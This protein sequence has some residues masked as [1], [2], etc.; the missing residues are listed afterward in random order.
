MVDNGA[1][2]VVGTFDTKATEL[3]YVADLVTDDERQ[4]LRLSRLVER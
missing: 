3:G 1:A 4:C 2:Y